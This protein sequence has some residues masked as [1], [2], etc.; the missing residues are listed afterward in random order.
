M[1]LATFATPL[2]LEFFFFT[3]VTR[4]SQLLSGNLDFEKKGI[5][6]RS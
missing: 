6:L 5:L 3:L 4:F 1:V 2:Q